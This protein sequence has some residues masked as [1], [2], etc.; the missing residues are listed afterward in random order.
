[1]EHLKNV[2]LITMLVDKSLKPPDLSKFK[3]K[4]IQ[5]L[6][7]KETE[8]TNTI[9][10]LETERKLHLHHFLQEQQNE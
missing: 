5:S 1:M 9:N 7:N 10:N 8:R 2:L 4:M 6:K 3:Q